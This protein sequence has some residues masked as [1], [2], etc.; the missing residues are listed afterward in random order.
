[1]LAPTVKIIFEIE[2][3]KGLFP[4]FVSP[5]HFNKILEQNWFQIIRLARKMQNPT[6]HFGFGAFS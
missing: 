3:I 1:V 2:R 5:R 6:F 4:N